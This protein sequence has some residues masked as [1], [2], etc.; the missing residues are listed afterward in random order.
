MSYVPG[1]SQR[2]ESRPAVPIVDDH[3]RQAGKAGEEAGEADPQPIGVSV[4]RQRVPETEQ[5]QADD[6]PDR[7]AAE[8]EW[9]GRRVERFQLQLRRRFRRHV[10]SVNHA[11]DETSTRD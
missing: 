8:R 5:D 11:L 9:H 7:H 10:R 4:C 3:R 6:G 2:R 1:F